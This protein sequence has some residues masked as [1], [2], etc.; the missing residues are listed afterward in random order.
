[1]FYVI[2]GVV[3]ELPEKELAAAASA[4]MTTRILTII[5][6]VDAIAWKFFSIKGKSNQKKRF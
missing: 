3:G 1:M 6:E 2:S 4:T 5:K